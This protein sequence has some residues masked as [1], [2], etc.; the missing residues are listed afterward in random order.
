MTTLKGLFKQFK[1]RHKI[2]TTTTTTRAT[3]ITTTRKI[4][5]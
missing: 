5:K 3:T 4:N 2:T 1:N